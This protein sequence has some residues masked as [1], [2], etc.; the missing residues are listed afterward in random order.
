MRNQW[1]RTARVA[2]MCAAMAALASTAQAQTAGIQGGVVQSPAQL[3]AGLHVESTPIRRRVTLRPAVQAATGEGVRS[4]HGNL[5]VVFRPYTAASIWDV[6][7]GGGPS[8]NSYWWTDRFGDLR[9][10]GIGGGLVLGI[11]HERQIFFELRLG[12]G[13]SPHFK[14]GIGYAFGQ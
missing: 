4:L 13:N 10:S 2:V 8:A 14:F 7:L 12:L 6:Y 11:E 5:D 9:E 3:F 1:T